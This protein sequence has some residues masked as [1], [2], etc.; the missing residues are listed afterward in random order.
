MQK[1]RSENGKRGEVGAIG[2]PAKRSEPSLV[3]ACCPAGKVS[4]FPA[5]GSS[6]VWDILE[7]AH[8]FSQVFPTSP[9]SLPVL[10]P[11]SDPSEKKRR[12][13]SNRGLV[14]AARSFP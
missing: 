11:P 6:V 4:S 2:G 5:R 8:A 14:M 7:Q 1:G 10:L 9:E 12:L 13:S 3:D